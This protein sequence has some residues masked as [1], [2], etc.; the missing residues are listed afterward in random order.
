MSA[1]NP[2]LSESLSILSWKKASVC[3]PPTSLQCVWLSCLLS[4]T[5]SLIYHFSLLCPNALCF[6]CLI[7]QTFIY[8][9][10]SWLCFCACGGQLPPGW[11]DVG[12]ITNGKPPLIS[13]LVILVWL[14]C[15]FIEVQEQ[16]F[17]R[18]CMHKGY[19]NS[20]SKVALCS[21][22]PHSHILS[23]LLL[24]WH[25]HCSMENSF[26]CKQ[27]RCYHELG[28]HTHTHTNTMDTKPAPGFSW[29]I[30][31]QWLFLNEMIQKE[32]ATVSLFDK[33]PSVL[34]RSE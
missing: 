33:K 22:L 16:A 5:H 17:T 19:N 18:M 24:S 27:L 13:C 10:Q 30:S 25:C 14:I 28:K 4:H 34:R 20:L 7:V 29:I 6:K 15:F 2:Q 21:G 31:Y 12:G 9:M 11:Q 1:Y 32:W 26:A 3:L 23:A 8:V